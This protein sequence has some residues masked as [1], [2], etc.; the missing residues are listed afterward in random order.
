M[1]GWALL[2]I[3]ALTPASARAETQ[4]RIYDPR[5]PLAAVAAPPRDGWGTFATVGGR[6]LD[7]DFHD[8]H[9]PRDLGWSGDPRLPARDVEAGFGWRGRTASA[10]IGYAEHP[11]AP[12]RQWYD[13]FD[14]NW[15]GK[16]DRGV[17]GLS[18]S[19]RPR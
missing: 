19:F 3:W 6:T 11:V 5:P 4:T 15:P 18:V 13:R 14:P 17:V 7:F 1:R 9:D 8:L 12:A 10:L 16:G 2:V